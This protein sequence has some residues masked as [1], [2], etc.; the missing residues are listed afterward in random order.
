MVISKTVN[1]LTRT[2]AE[3]ARLVSFKEN[4]SHI[5]TYK[6]LP[7]EAQTIAMA[8]YVH[9]QEW[10]TLMPKVSRSTLIQRRKSAKQ[11]TTNN[12]DD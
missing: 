10:L 8:I 4:L 3:I 6:Y 7:T 9:T 5:L 1:F 12:K 11:T 2:L